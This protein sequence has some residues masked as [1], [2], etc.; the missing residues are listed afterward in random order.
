[1]KSRSDDIRQRIG[2]IIHVAFSGSQRSLAQAVGMSAPLISRVLA[3]EMKPSGKLIAAISDLPQINAVW[4]RTGKGEPIQ[5]KPQI[6]ADIG[7]IVPVAKRLLPGPLL[8]FES[9]L[10]HKFFSVPRAFYSATTYAI[11]VQSCGCSEEFLKKERLKPDDTLI[12]VTDAEVC[13]NFDHD[14]NNRL[15]VCCFPE[16]GAFLAAGAQYAKNT[17]ARENAS[18]HLA[19]AEFASP[20]R[21]RSIDLDDDLAPANMKQERGKNPG[22]GDHTELLRPVGVVTLMTRGY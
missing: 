13:R 1:M 18:S 12:V 16:D 19:Q 2:K 17:V 7:A 3:G 10:T 14:Q 11:E 8:A 6:L 5:T 9:L 15:C 4:L 21:R 20:R 22:A